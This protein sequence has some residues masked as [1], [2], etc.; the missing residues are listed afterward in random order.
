[1][2]MN[3]TPLPFFPSKKYLH[4]ITAKMTGIGRAVSESAEK[5]RTMGSVAP[6]FLLCYNYDRC[7]EYLFF[8]EKRGDFHHG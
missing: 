8:F 3:P 4:D 6:I 7:V 1:M 2:H 5:K